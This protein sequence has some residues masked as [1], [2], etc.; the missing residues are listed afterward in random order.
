MRADNVR[1]ALALA[2]A[3]FYPRQPGTI[4]AVTGTSGKTS[5]AAF[6]RQIW[7]ALGHEAASI[8]TIGLVTPKQEVYGSLTTPDPIELA[9]TLDRLAEDG[10]THLAMEASS[11]GLDQH[12]IDGVRVT[13]GGFTNLSRDHMDYHATERAYLDAKLILFE[14]IVAPHGAAV[15][16]AD[17]AFADQ[18]IAAAAGRGLRVLTVGRNGH[19][20]PADR[21]RGR[22]LLA[23]LAPR[24]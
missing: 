7:A 12:R 10:I 6:T 11:H 2:A 19:R 24:A 5:V 17:N 14:R 4:A 22:R 9:R 13:V 15:V 20:H 21:R 3:R 18:V 1:R 16:A 8:G 23:D